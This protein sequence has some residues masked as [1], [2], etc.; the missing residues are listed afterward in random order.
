[1]VLDAGYGLR[2]APLLSDFPCRHKLLGTLVRLQVAARGIDVDDIFLQAFDLVAG[3][4]ERMGEE[5]G[6]LHHQTDEDAAALVL[7][8]FLDDAE[9]RVVPAEDRHPRLD[10]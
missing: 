4:E 10:L 6:R 3:D 2:S 5:A 1:M 7:E 9:I 8:Y